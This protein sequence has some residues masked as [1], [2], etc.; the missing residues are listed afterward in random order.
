MRYLSFADTGGI[1]LSDVRV[2]GSFLQR[3]RGLLG[4]DKLGPSEGLLL[5]NCSSIHMFGMRFALDIV[6]LDREGTVI[7]IVENLAPWRMAYV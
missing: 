3:A 4:S 6:F 1:A 5:E 7:K 2:P